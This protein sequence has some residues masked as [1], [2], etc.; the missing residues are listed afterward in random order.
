MT[1]TDSGLTHRHCH[2]AISIGAWVPDKRAIDIARRIFWRSATGVGS[3][4]TVNSSNP[5]IKSSL[6]LGSL[7]WGSV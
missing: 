7:A 6:G 5:L 1:T 2:S 4:T 3:T